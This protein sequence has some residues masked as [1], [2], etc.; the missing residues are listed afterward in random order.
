MLVGYTV[1]SVN[2]ISELEKA[3]TSSDSIDSAQFSNTKSDK[4]VGQMKSRMT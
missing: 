2:E 1:G 3:P 4:K